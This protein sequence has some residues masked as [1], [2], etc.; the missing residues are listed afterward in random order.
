MHILNVYETLIITLFCYNTD[1]NIT[2]SK[3]SNLKFPEDLKTGQTIANPTSAFLRAGPSLVPSPVTA[4]TSRLGL[5]RLS[6]IP[7][8]R[9]CLSDGEDLAR[10]R[11]FGHTL[12][13]SSGFTWHITQNPS[14]KNIRKSL[15]LMHILSIIQVKIR[16]QQFI[17]Y[18]IQIFYSVKPS[19]IYSKKKASISWVSDEAQLEQNLH[20][21]TSWPCPLNCHGLIIIIIIISLTSIFFQDKSRVWTAASQLH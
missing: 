10:T 3:G 14:A 8:T 21:A 9:V 18:L 4:T 12:S 7:L 6:M 2:K 15:N 5:S 11:S 17:G 20:W 1:Q 16:V 19:C 13:K